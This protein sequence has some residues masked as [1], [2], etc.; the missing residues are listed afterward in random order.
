MLA[1]WGAVPLALWCTTPLAQDTDAVVVTGSRRPPLAPSVA[2]PLDER[3]QDAPAQV[4]SIPSERLRVPGTHRASDVLQHD[5]SV[6]EN[7]AA[8]GYAENFLIRGFTLD[9]GSAY[10]INGFVV[11]GE[12]LLGLDNRERIEVLKGI[13]LAASGV[14]SPGGVINFVS[15]RPEPVAQGR[16]ELTPR[17]ARYAAFDAG[18]AVV[19]VNAAHEDLR[20]YAPRATGRRDFASLAFD[21]A[22]SSGVRLAADLEMHRR[23]QFG[24]PG[25]QLLGGTV[26]PDVSP[27]TNLNQQSWIRPVDNRSAFGAL[28]GEFELSR[29]WTLRA[30]ASSAR[31]R[32]ED[33]LAF[34][35]GCNDAP[36]QYFCADGGYVLYDYRSNEVRAG[37]HAQA[38][39]LGRFVT[40]GVRHR[41]AFGLERV[42][43]RVAMRGFYSATLSDAAGRGLTGNIAD[44]SIPLAAP[45]GTPA[46][47]AD[48]RMSQSG[49]YLAD[50]MAW[51]EWRAQ[52]ALRSV[53][54][55]QSQNGET[56]ATHV[57]PQAALV[58]R[59][60]ARSQAYVALLRGVEFG[61]EA[62]LV[63]ENAGRLLPPRRTR[64]AELGWKHETAGGLALSG[65]L[66]RMARPY[67]FT[68][69]N[70][71]SF[72]GLGM[73]QRAGTQV[74]SGAELSARGEVAPRL[75]I[76]ASAAAIDARAHGTGVPAYDNVQIQSVPHLRSSLQARY[77]L[78]DL[79]GVELS[80]AWLHSGRRNARRDGIAS[81]PGYDRL[82][83]GVSWE[84]VAGGLKSRLMLNVTNLANRRYW[85]DAS[86]AY[87]AD[88]LFPGAPREVF[89]GWQVQ[90]F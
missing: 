36:V 35:Y 87:S 89:L 69:P 53:R 78:A 60:G 11:P 19:R 84:F 76:V 52:A 17:G 75:R 40:G 9:P 7:F 42:A 16:F 2:G 51:G 86:E 29:G 26:V 33:N 72:A 82:D 46:D 63:A 34:P 56:S 68:L 74:H 57:L 77:A 47:R 59:L 79:P 20:P 39:L 80:A 71:T 90:G 37:T 54:V 31:A 15:R 5:A 48:A 41:L 13:G 50:E 24:V 12:M 28:R 44:P 43:R 23:T 21:A 22:P 32:I 64:Q 55:V 14:S 73:F 85:R 81:V 45:V 4:L 49:A 27:R 58:R 70:G 18:N 88:L 67:D 83:A 25:F 1:L 38:S 65:A 66:F 61:G 10:R 3:P 30:G 62:P 6:G 8:I